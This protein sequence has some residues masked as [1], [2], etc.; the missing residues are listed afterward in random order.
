MN[1]EEGGKGKKRAQP[2]ENL[3]KGRKVWQSYRA[4]GAKVFAAEDGNEKSGGG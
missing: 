2:T 1:E 3:K 4:L